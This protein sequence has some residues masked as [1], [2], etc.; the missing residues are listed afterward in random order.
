MC[1]AVI[2]L[3]QHHNMP[4]LACTVRFA[5]THARDKALFPIS[6]QLHDRFSFSDVRSMERCGTLPPQVVL[7]TS[8]GPIAFTTTDHLIQYLEQYVLFRYGTSAPAE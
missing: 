4:V 7:A 2:L 6:N 1:I 8:S 5:S 3:Q